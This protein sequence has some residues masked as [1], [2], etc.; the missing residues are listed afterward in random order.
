MRWPGG[1][2]QNIVRTNVPVGT[3]ERFYR[4]TVE[5]P[6]NSENHLKAI[7]DGRQVAGRDGFRQ[8]PKC[9]Q[10]KRGAKEKRRRTGLEA[11]SRCYEVLIGLMCV[12]CTPISCAGDVKS[13]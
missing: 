5:I 9:R 4:K 2:G 8:V 1:E 6:E 11:G 10:E 12:R 3:L 7:V 13:R